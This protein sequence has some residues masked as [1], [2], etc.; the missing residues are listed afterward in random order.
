MN[1]TT[2]LEMAELVDN[3][4]LSLNKKDEHK[5][6]N[7]INEANNLHY[8]SE[9]KNLKKNKLKILRILVTISKG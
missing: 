7:K 9:I 6:A 2:N 4:V 8:N 3:T 5:K 1:G